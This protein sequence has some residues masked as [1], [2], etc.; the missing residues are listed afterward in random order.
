MWWKLLVNPDMAQLLMVYLT[1]SIV[2]T[3][4]VINRRHIHT[5]STSSLQLS[6]AVVGKFPR[7]QAESW[8]GDDGRTHFSSINQKGTTVA[9][10][11]FVRVSSGT[12]AEKVAYVEDLAQAEGEEVVLEVRWL[13]PAGECCITSWSY[14]ALLNLRGRKK[15]LGRAIYN[16][17]EV[18]R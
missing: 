4:S 10:H 7:R 18:D 12:G 13:Q 17:R 15:L 9:A 16:G 2:G 8:W 1:S 11:D 5:V 14:S 3:C 6:S